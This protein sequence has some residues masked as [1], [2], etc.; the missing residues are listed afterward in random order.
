M[1]MLRGGWPWKL[2]AAVHWSMIFI[3]AGQVALAGE[4]QYR[5]QVVGI[6]TNS[7]LQ[8]LWR[9][10][11][12]DK[13]GRKDLLTLD[14]VDHTIGVYRQA[15]TGF[16]AAPQQAIELP[17]GSP[18][19]A[20]AEVE[21]GAGRALVIATAGG[22]SYLRQKDG[23]FERELRPLVSGSQVFTNSELS[24]LA[25]LKGATNAA[26][27]TLPIIAAD[28]AVLYRRDAG[29]AW[30]A[31]ETLPL[32]LRP[33]GLRARP[34]DWVTIAQP[35]RTLNIWQPRFAATNDWRVRD[36]DE[37]TAKEILQRIEKTTGSWHVADRVD[38]DGRRD[39]VVWS[40]A[41][42]IDTRTDVSL[43][44]LGP[45]NRL[46]QQPSQVL[47][48]RGFPLRAGPEDRGVPLVDL[49]GD[50][51]CEL[52]LA[53]LKPSVLTSGGIADVVVSGAMDWVL[54]VRTF[55]NGAFSTRADASLTFT[56]M[57]PPEKGPENFIFL[58][59]DFNGDGRRD[60]LVRRSPTLWQV[61]LSTTNGSW[62]QPKPGLTFD[63]AEDGEFFIADLNGDGCSDLVVQPWN[64]P[65]LLV[66][67]STGR[68]RSLRSP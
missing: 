16:P 39:L 57:L 58:E 64:Q 21:L 37:E 15:A 12:L 26:H 60:L 31:T 40:C 1:C 33:G 52:V 38:V 17:K 36:P 56:T 6:P 54:A 50:G 59:G 42:Y 46:P 35:A 55:K 29:G 11:E 53:R 68:P 2:L 61:Y 65:R 62:F 28:H 3:I 24:V 7:C 14:P 47:R 20:L 34:A 67:M 25:A 63:I 48:C 5:R 8:R 13:D 9:F 10:V 41:G 43:Y 45:D 32:E 49:D 4:I 27:L 30:Q 44:L 22:L 18:W 19:C 66:F 23:V 51:H